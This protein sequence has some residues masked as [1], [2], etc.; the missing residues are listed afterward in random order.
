[1]KNFLTANKGALTMFGL[2]AVMIAASLG[3]SGCQLDQVIKV[4]VPK[5]VQTATDSQPKV[6][7]ADS[8]LLWQEWKNYVDINTEALRARIGDANNQYSL[9]ASITSMG[10]ETAGGAASTLPGG[11]FIVAGLTGLGGLFLKKPGTDRMIQKE[12]E[13]SYNK[14]V[15]IGKETTNE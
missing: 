11:A 10:L 14:G 5:D 8:D 4:D 15:K 13:A 1:M 3:V 9:V 12:K 2:S 6:A 7:L